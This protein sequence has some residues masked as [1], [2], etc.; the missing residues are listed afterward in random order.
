MSSLLPFDCHFLVMS[1]LCIGFSPFFFFCLFLA[2]VFSLGCV[3]LC[4][5]LP[6]TF[7]GWVPILD[8]YLQS[9]SF[10]IGSDHKLFMILDSLVVLK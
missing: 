5:H 9:F 6:C 3:Y 7:D 8:F 1:L 4:S 2:F 10:R